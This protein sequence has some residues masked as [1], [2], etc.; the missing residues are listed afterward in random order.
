MAKAT[1]AELEQKLKRLLIAYL[2]GNAHAYDIR[3]LAV[4]TDTLRDIRTQPQWAYLIE[5]VFNTM[6]AIQDGKPVENYHLQWWKGVLAWLP[7][8]SRLAIAM[9]RYAKQNGLTLKTRL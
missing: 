1:H 3:V 8:H 4:K 6:S 5:C 7:K 9:R 2:E